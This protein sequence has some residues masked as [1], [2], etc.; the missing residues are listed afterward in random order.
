MGFE[1]DEVKYRWPDGTGMI[2]FGMSPWVG[3]WKSRH[4]LMSR[5]SRGMPVLYVQPWVG[6]RS[7]RSQA[8]GI[9]R[10][11]TDLGRP[12]LEKH[13]PNVHVFNSPAYL[14][15]SRSSVLAPITQRLWTA[16]VRRAARSIGITRPIVWVSR[17]ETGFV[18]GRM[19]EQLSIYHVVDEYA[20]YTGAGGQAGAKLADAEAV[21]LDSVNL[22]VVAS[23]ELERAKQGSA[24]DLVVLENG[25]E[26]SEYAD[27]RDSGLEPADLADVSRPRIG[28]SGLIGKR[29]DLEL[30]RKIALRRPDCSVVLIGKVD[31]RECEAGLAA[32]ESLPN[33]Y[34]LGEKP[35]A[36]VA[37]YV[38]GFD[39]GLLP[40]AIN[41]ETQHISPI[42]MYEYWAAGKPVVAT[43]IPAA[44]RNR[45]AVNVAESHNEFLSAID[46][47][48]DEPNQE[49]PNRLIEL[50]GRNSWQSRVEHVA[51]EL[52]SRIGDS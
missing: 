34:L 47:L 16:A 43:S 35:A 45:S 24:R 4:Q 26:P 20:G 41:L 11:F 22:V 7:L 17:P 52:S 21:V 25:V 14:P 46:R 1:P 12:L 18:V 15:V 13:D 19:N 48:L 28:Y 27:A 3:M 2:Y 8:S 29:L 44:R 42:K 33:V 38:I 36:E 37:R 39:I 50:A 10:I 49:D 5:F 31:A 32:L 23:P 30:I 6:L 51:A 40:Y 9:S